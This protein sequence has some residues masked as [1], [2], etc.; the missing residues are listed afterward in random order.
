[1]ANI[2]NDDV[3]ARVRRGEIPAILATDTTASQDIWGFLQKMPDNLWWAFYDPKHV[4][5]DDI[6]RLSEKALRKFYQPGLRVLRATAWATSPRFW[7]TGID[8]LKAM[9]LDSF[10]YIEPILHDA[11]KVALEQLD[12]LFSN[13]DGTSLYDKINEEAQSLEQLAKDIQ[14]NG[15]TEA[16]QAAYN[17]A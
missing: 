4:D 2:N 6:G 17:A 11:D 3:F 1:M 14:N 8:S 10:S 13:E 16:N 7:G 5:V 12:L 9:D 15:V